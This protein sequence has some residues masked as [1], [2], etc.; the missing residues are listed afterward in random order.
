MALSSGLNFPQGPIHFTMEKRG[1]KKTAGGGGRE[2][3]KKY[4]GKRRKEKAAE[5][6]LLHPFQPAMGAYVQAGRQAGKGKGRKK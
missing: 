5:K 1:K 6:P 4:M 2:K 3:V